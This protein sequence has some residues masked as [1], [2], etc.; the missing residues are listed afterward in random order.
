MAGCCEHGDEISGSINAGQLLA[1]QE[2][3]CCMQLESK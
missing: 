1:F 3:V 2:G